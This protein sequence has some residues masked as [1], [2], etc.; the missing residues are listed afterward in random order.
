MKSLIGGIADFA[1]AIFLTMGMGVVG[2]EIVNTIYHEIKV[3]TVKRV[4]QGLDPLTPYTQRM[5]GT[6]L[7][8]RLEAIYLEK[9]GRNE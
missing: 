3:A 2:C 8:K 5:T 9:R 6:N 4:H 1:L 7:E